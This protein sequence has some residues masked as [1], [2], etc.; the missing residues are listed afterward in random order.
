MLPHRLALATTAAVTVPTVAWA[1]SDSGTDARGY[2]AQVVGSAFALYAGYIAIELLAEILGAYLTF[3]VAAP[4]MAEAV[5]LAVSGSAVG[6]ATGLVVAVVAI[7]AILAA[8]V[9]AGMVYQYVIPGLVNYAQGQV[10][11]RGNNGIEGNA[12]CCADGSSVGIGGNTATVGNDGIPGF[13]G[14][15]DVT[16]GFADGGGIC[17][18]GTN[19]D[20]G[21]PE[22]WIQGPDGWWRH[23]DYE[24]WNVVAIAKDLPEGAMASEHYT[25]ADVLQGYEAYRILLAGGEYDDHDYSRVSGP[26]ALLLVGLGLALAL[27][28]RRA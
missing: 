23:Y 1:E 16:I 26:A 5:A 3:E 4:L 7:G 20:P 12:A 25:Y 6:V 13:Q 14:A 11:A 8:A 10:T 18:P 24:Y 21:D 27:R 19:G 17:C 22:G 9:A 2:Y 28:R 15:L